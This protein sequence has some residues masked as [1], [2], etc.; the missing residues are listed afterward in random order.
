MGGKILPIWEVPKPKWL[1]KDLYGHLALLDYG[2]TPFYMNSPN[3]WG[4]NFAVKA[5][6]FKKYGGFDTNRGRIPGKLYAGEETYFL[7]KLLKGG[8]KILYYP[9]AVIYHCIPKDRISKKYFRKWN[10]DQGELHARL[11]GDYRKRNLYRVPYYIIKQ[12]LIKMPFYFLRLVLFS[13]DSLKHELEI[14]YL[15]S[16]ILGRIKF[17][18]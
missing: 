14:I 8:D 10:F 5:D 9:K 17:K 3:I 16:F 7:E 4:A 13:K 15:W 12:L 1:K 18:H 2:D 11:L 6:L